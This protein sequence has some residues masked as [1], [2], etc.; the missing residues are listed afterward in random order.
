MLIVRPDFDRRI[1]LPGVGPCP[2]PVDIDRT[3]TGFRD[4][5][6]LRVYAFAAGST[7][8]GEAEDDEVFIVAMRGEADVAITPAGGATAA[9]ALRQGA[10]TRAL[11]MPPHAAYRLSAISDC[12]IAY[13]RAV[14][15]TP[16][17]PAPRAFAPV[18]GRLDV[19]DHASGMGLVLLPLREDSPTAF[20]EDKV[21]RIVHLRGGAARIAD[22]RLGDWDSVALSENDELS[23]AIEAGSAEI[24]VIA[25]RKGDRPSSP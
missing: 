21:E 1:D 24:L 10:G 15:R 8:N 5:V 14:P 23:I 18:D 3:G 17:A 9:F 22:Q 7:I 20:P 6:S 11:F 16:Q 4:L 13:A 12:D 19:A 2:R 25:A